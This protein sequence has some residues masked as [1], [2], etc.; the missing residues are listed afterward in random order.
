MK[1]QTRRA[2]YRKIEQERDTKVLTF[3]TSDRQGTETVIAHDC[4]DLFVDLLDQ[5][6]P[7]KKIS[8]I[9]HTNGGSTL[10]AWR[11]L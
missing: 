4:F 11:L 1:Y 6:G 10:A 7:T 5:I 8:L 2:L 3:V 9:L